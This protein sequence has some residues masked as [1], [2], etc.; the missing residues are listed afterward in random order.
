MA[1]VPEHPAVR[2]QR[3]P[4]ALQVIALAATIAALL[5]GL[6]L[7]ASPVSRGFADA[8]GVPAYWSS[9]GFAVAWFIAA[10]IVLGKVRKERPEFRLPLRVA[11]LLTVAAVGGVFAWTSLT[12]DKA[13]D[14]VSF[15]EEAVPVSQMPAQDTPTREQ[16][17]RNVVLSS[18]IFSGIDHSAEGRVRIVRLA[19]GEHRLVFTEFDVERAPDL[20]VYLA[21]DEVTG[22]IG[23]YREIDKLKGNVGD[24]FYK[25]P[26]SIDLDRY[27]HVVIWCKAFDVGVAQAPLA[28]S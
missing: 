28:E 5:A 19:N 18:G 17:K 4:L 14:D 1:D 16:P 20:R 7:F 27:R 21:E 25:L 23:P 22:D 8:A 9:I 6:W 24:Q 3:A 15:A 10:S 11:F 13:D 2:Q 12:D 26:R